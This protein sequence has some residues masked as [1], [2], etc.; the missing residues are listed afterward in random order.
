MAFICSVPGCQRPVHGLGL[1]G[2]HALRL[3]RGE[4]LDKP[5]R[6]R[7]RRYGNQK[8]LANDCS[9][10]PKIHGY[11]DLHAARIRTHGDHRAIEHCMASEY[12]GEW[13][14]CILRMH[15]QLRR[16]CQ[17]RSQWERWVDLKMLN[18]RRR[19]AI[20]TANPKLPTS[21]RQWVRR[22][23]SNSRKVSMRATS[24]P[25]LAWCRMRTTSTCRKT[26]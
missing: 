3:R 2:A 5:I 23:I 26:K 17:V 7:I 1:C 12:A 13:S 21:W 25:W 8:C 6:L 11:C 16:S 22:G 19:P 14:E 9:R 10:R 4:P 18:L 15:Q 20:K 24:N